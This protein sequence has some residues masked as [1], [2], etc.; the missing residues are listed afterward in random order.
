M[1]SFPDSGRRHLKLA[2]LKTIHFSR[3]HKL[4][5]FDQWDIPVKLKCHTNL[6][7]GK[8]GYAKRKKLYERMC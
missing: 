1:F 8:M 7:R 3:Q 5:N 4:C 2:G 6:Q